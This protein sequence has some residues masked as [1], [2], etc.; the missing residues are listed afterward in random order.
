MVLVSGDG[1]KRSFLFLH[2]LSTT[3]HASRTRGLNQ[4]A[5]R[6]TLRKQSA[7]PIDIIVFDL[8]SRI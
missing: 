6:Y 5:T 4:V 1:I 2:K 7:K 8:D 3:W